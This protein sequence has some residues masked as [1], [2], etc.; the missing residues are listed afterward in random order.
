MRNAQLIAQLKS[1]LPA[2]EGQTQP[3]TTVAEAGDSAEGAQ[4]QS[5]PSNPF[6]F[7]TTHPAAVALNVGASSTST[8][9]P[10]TDT[11]SFTLSQLPHLQSLLAAVRPSL[12]TLRNDVDADTN[13][14]DGRRKYIEE[15]TKRHLQ[16][17]QG[18]ELGEQGEVRDGGW[19]GRGKRPGEGQVRDLETIVGTLG[20]AT[21]VAGEKMDERE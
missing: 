9:H 11:T 19:Q 10:I 15:Q 17:T 7:L 16:T 6:A 3:P 14:P 4:Q 2:A 8:N 1:L 5:A 20:G 21:E 12:T 13:T 18:L